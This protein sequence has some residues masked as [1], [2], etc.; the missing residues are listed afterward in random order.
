[1]GSEQP[2][3]SCVRR[4]PDLPLEKGNFGGRAPVAK[5]R[6]SAVTRAKTAEPNVMLFRLWA[7]TGPS[8]HELH[9]GPDPHEKGQF[10]GKGSPTVN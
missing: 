6:N 5:Y 3:K 4:G 8:N 2:K 1:M 9:E 10:L 7:R